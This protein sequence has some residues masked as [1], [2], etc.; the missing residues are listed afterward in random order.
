MEEQNLNK[1]KVDDNMMLPII[2]KITEITK[3]LFEL[4]QEH[5]TP[6]K[7]AYKNMMVSLK[8]FIS[9]I[10]E[11]SKNP[12]S[13]ISWMDY[14]KI[15]K[16]CVW[17][18][19]YKLAPEELKTITKEAMTEEEFDKYMKKHFTKDVVVSLSKDT[20][21]M[22]PKKHKT[23]YKQAIAAYFNKSYALCNMGLIGI[24]DDLT[25]F[26]IF[27]KGLS[28]R[29]GLFKPVVDQTELLDIADIDSSHFTL[30]MLSEN[31]DM[32]YTDTDFNNQVRP[33]N[34]K[35]IS[36][37]SSIHGKYYSNKRESTLTLLNTIY[38]LLQVISNFKQFKD[39]LKYNKS[40]KCFEIIGPVPKI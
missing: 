18:Y 32:L 8:P 24:I 7:E 3:P 26:F 15:L 13:V 17:A 10:S 12:D 33:N 25:S 23:I 22:M 28:A 14:C 20:L 1:G 21:G 34:N 4:V 19:P 16:E 9:A 30:M 35:G 40:T 6:I 36:R 31:L 29:K 5:I 27:N 39:K 38:Y 37:H 2:N 11:A